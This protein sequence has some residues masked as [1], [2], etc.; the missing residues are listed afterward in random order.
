MGVLSFVNNALGAPTPLVTPQMVDLGSRVAAQRARDEAESREAAEI[1]AIRKSLTG[2]HVTNGIIESLDPTKRISGPDWYGSPSKMGIGKRMMLE[3]DV[4]QSVSYLTAPI[5][6]GSP[7][8]RPASKDPTDIEAADFA[9][10]CFCELL[11]WT[12]ITERTLR[13][14]FVDGVSLSEMT[15]TSRA[16]PRG[17]FP[18][19]PGGGFGV[20]PSGIHEVPASTVYRWYQRA[21]NTAQMAGIQQYTIGGDNEKAGLTDI[22]A[23]RL[24]RLT[25]DQSG[26]DYEG[27]PL[28]RSAY[29]YWKLKS[30]F[31][32]IMAIKHDRLGVGVPVAEVVEGARV[33]KE[34]IDAAFMTLAAMRSGA[35]NAIVLPGGMKF[36]WA[37]AGK[38]FGS[39]VELAIQI[40]DQEIAKNVAAGFM[41]LGL[42]GGGGSYALGSTQQGQ[43]HLFVSFQAKR[44][45]DL[46]NLGSDGWSPIERLVRMNYGPNVGTPRLEIRGLPTAPI[47]QT[48]PILINGGIAGMITPDLRLEN[49]MR[50]ALGFDDL[51]EETARPRG[52]QP[53]DGAMMP[54]E[55][56]PD[57]G[58]EDVEDE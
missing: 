7:K 17:R 43:H 51:D 23:D 8:F 4:R 16:V 41:L 3:V 40:C 49:D 30:A 14:A 11:P 56:Q 52:P 26:A 38:D 15:E 2:T 55:P 19:H 54:M 33:S 6:G 37:G 35:K 39:N 13:N 22:T 57:E 31:L 27:T 1:R 36:T 42:Q 25:Y 28:L 44:Y 50:E 12:Q 58:S 48:A 21:D 20:V 29:P 32:T 10:W 9:K 53:A 34:D 5:C 46:W 47:L 45:C 24:L 18:L